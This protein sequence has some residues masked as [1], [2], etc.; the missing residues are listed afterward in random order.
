MRKFSKIS[1]GTM[2]A[3][4]RSK[5]SERFVAGHYVRSTFLRDATEMLEDAK[6]D[7]I[8]DERADGPFVEV[9]LDDL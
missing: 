3:N 1:T 7:A 6:L 5:R 2:S 8:A 9:S 4:A